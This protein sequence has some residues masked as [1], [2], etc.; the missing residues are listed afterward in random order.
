MQKMFGQHSATFSEY[1]FTNTD[2]RNSK[3]ENPVET[4]GKNK[5][6]K[7]TSKR[8]SRGERLVT[9][10]GKPKLRKAKQS[11][12]GGKYNKMSEL[13]KKVSGY[14]YPSKDCAT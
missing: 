14:T 13:V 8:Y 6:K 12:P 3:S 7:L 1:L 9:K 5:Q 2:E 11:C 4:A 10:V